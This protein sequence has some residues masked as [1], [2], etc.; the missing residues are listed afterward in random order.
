MN[1]LS[2]SRM[3]DCSPASAAAMLLR[4]RSA[5][6]SS[7]MLPGATPIAVAI[8]RALAASRSI[9]GRLLLGSP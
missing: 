1:T 6:L 9:P 8:L 4:V 7:V 3:R 5:L 2:P